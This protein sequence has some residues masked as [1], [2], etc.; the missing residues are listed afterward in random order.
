MGVQGRAWPVS[1]RGPVR[2]VRGIGSETRTD[3]GGSELTGRDGL[4]PGMAWGPRSSG[5]LGVN[6]D[7]QPGPAVG[8]LGG[9]QV[10][11]GPV[12]GLFPEAV[13]VLNVESA[14]DGLPAVVHVH[15]GGAGLGGASRMG[16]PSGS[17]GG[18]STSSRIRVPSMRGSSP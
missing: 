14:R 17:P 12:T 11:P 13:G 18:C 6:D 16:G 2:R 9:A 10:G 15:A 1:V 5:G 8:I 4:F 3:S 7:E